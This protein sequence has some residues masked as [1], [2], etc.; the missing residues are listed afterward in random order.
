MMPRVNSEQT[1][2]ELCIWVFVFLTEFLL[3]DA[4]EIAFTDRSKAILLWWFFLFY[5]LVFKIFLCCWR[6][7]YVFIFL[8]KLR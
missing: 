7:M 4:D 5:V 3:H 2:I 8:I 1:N 6:L